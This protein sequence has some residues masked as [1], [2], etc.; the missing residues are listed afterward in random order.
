MYPILNGFR[1]IATSVHSSLELVPNTL[2]PS[3]MWIG[4][5]HQL[6]AV[7]VDS[8]TVGV[9]WK[10]PHIFI[11]AKYSDMLCAVQTRVA[12]HTDVDGGIFKNILY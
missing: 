7:T 12:K 8:D 10:M 4:V 6:A 2:L 1:D 3:G 9:L 11:N 5:K